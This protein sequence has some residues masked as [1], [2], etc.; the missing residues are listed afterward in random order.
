MTELTRT[1]TEDH[2]ALA[3]D[4][5]DFALRTATEPLQAR[6]TSVFG[7]VFFASPSGALWLLDTLEGSLTR[8]WA[9]RSELDAELA[10]VEGQDAVLMSTF[11][12][13]AERAGIIP[14][15][16]QILDFTVAPAL[17]GSF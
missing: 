14:G 10:T 11:V 17:G 9:V 12:Q 4:A 15:E 5:W 6:F 8:R 16:S 7:W 3:L 13:M 1:W 2:Y